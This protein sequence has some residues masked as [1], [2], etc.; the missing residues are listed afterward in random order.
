MLSTCCQLN[1]PHFQHLLLRPRF[2]SIGHK[3]LGIV[4]KFEGS[5]NWERAVHPQSRNLIR[6]CSC[7]F[8][9]SHLSVCPIKAEIK[10]QSIVLQGSRSVCTCQITWEAISVRI[11]STLLGQARNRLLQARSGSSSEQASNSAYASL[12]SCVYKA[13]VLSDLP[14]ALTRQ[15]GNWFAQAKWKGKPGAQTDRTLACYEQSL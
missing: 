1:L 14:P 5:C 8:L 13:G 7:S 6:T 15:A 11:P 12:M 4:S 9:T 2:W 10:A 3:P